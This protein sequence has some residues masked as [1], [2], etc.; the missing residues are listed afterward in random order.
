D[1]AA[2]AR[3]TGRGESARVV[4]GDVV[5]SVDHFTGANS[6]AVKT[7]ITFGGDDDRALHRGRDA[8]GDDRATTSNTATVVGEG[9]VGHCQCA[10]T[11][12][13]PTN[14]T[15]NIARESAVDHGHETGAVKDSGT[16][17]GFVAG[18][19]AVGHRQRMIRASVK[20]PTP[21]E[22]S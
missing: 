11:R 6:M 19:G 3:G 13:P 1:A 10:A 22:G 21:A 2:V 8:V 7:R 17:A 16:A 5:A 4:I 18:E 20:N 14:N 9:A 15:C 12:N